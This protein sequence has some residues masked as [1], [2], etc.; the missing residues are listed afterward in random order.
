MVKS[1]V[2]DLY[3]SINDSNSNFFNKVDILMSWS[4]NEIENSKILS[5]NSDFKSEPPYILN[6]YNY[7]SIVKKISNN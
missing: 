5:S 7:Y 1:V 6:Y 3:S 2:T 4:L